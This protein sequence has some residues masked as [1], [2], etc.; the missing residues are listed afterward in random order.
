MK[1][2]IAAI[3]EAKATGANTAELAAKLK[4]AAAQAEVQGAIVGRQQ[5]IASLWTLPTPAY[6]RKQGEVK[7]LEAQL[8]LLLG[9]S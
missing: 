1:S 8:T 6:V 3:A 5:T 9:A 4:I 7:E 2:C